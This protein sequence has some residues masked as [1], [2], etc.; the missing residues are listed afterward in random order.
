[1]ES[2]TK[3]M[4]KELEKEFSGARSALM[5][6]DRQDMKGDNDQQEDVEELSQ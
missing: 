2:Q 4:N 1:M 3:K 5:D 6:D